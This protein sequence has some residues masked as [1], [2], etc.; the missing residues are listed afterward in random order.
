MLALIERPIYKASNNILKTLHTFLPYSKYKNVPLEGKDP[1]YRSPHD[2]RR[3]CSTQ[4]RIRSAYI[5]L[6][7]KPEG[8]RPLPRPRCGR[9][10]NIKTHLQETEFQ[11]DWI[12]VA[13]NRD[14]V[15][16]LRVHKRQGIS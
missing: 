7:G 13:Q 9:E 14:T 3:A 1:G 2:G 4:G 5:I 6:I 12:Y 16:N 15:M 11:E 10:D 8:K